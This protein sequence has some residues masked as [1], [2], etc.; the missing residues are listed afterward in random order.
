[1]LRTGPQKTVVKGAFKTVFLALSFVL[2]CS[3]QPKPLASY[4]WKLP[5]GFPA[6][7]VPNDN[8]MTQAKVVLGQQL[9]FDQAL[10]FN[11]SLACASCHLPEFAFAEPKKFAQ[12]A[13]GQVLRRN[14]QALV[15]VAYNSNLTWAHS[16][17]QTIEQQI[18][19]PMFTEDPIELG[20]TGHEQEVLQRFE[21]GT[22]PQ[23]FIDA[24]GNSSASFEHI[25]QALASYVRSLI[26]FN[27]AFDRYAY[28]ADD[29]AL[30]ASAIR[31]MD[32]FF[33][34]RLECF[35]CHGGVNFTQSSQHENQRLDLRP[36][37]N[38]GLFNVDG[39]GAYP[40]EDQ[41]LIEI[42]LQHNDMG[43]FRAPSL[44][45]VAVTAPY[46]HD[47]SMEDLSQVI[48]FYA[49]GGRGAGVD[50]PIKSVFV[51]GFNLTAD[52]KNDLLAF[53]HSLSDQEFLAN[54]Q[55]KP[56]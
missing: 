46:M 7:I 51:K 52:E 55:T 53:L 49:N 38:T 41:G 50:S 12:G 32:L 22:Y 43:R 34:E 26:S 18:L 33:S 8:P 9:F 27:S 54:T 6:P 56:K 48:D 15:N 1:M 47:G 37:H 10:S 42:T 16:G 31:G 35:H 44:R 25:V 36:F 40:Q 24:F 45:N 23:L 28:K 30:S 11:Q 20:I 5:A 3:C 39:T 17:L 13:T 14:T 21:L 4:D 29:E 2:L 19:I